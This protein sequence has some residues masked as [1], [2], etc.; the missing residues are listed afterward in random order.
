MSLPHILFIDDEPSLCLAMRLLLERHGFAVRTT[1]TMDGAVAEVRS[2][3][4]DAVVLDF[5]LYQL[6]KG[7]GGPGDLLYAELV[8]LDSELSRRIIFVTGDP[9]DPTRARMEKT[10]ASYLLKP[11]EIGLLVNSLRAII[12]TEGVRP[13]ARTSEQT[14]TRSA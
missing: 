12:D 11:F 14:G 3:R 5:W 8:A 2:T 7:R 1:M 13:A 6:A 9:G 4:F 10:G